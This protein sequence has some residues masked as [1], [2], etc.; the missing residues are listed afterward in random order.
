M[1]NNYTQIIAGE[2]AISHDRVTAAT[3]LLREGATIPFIA[4]YRKET[5]GSMDEVELSAVR[6]R[7]AQLEELDKRRDVI[8]KSLDTRGLLTDELKAKVVGACT[9]TEL[10]D[11]YL[12][13][14]PKRRTR[15]TVAREKGL[16]QLAESIFLQDASLDPMAEAAGYVDAEKGVESAEDALS[17]ARDIIAE[18]VSEDQ[19]A[20]NR[21]RDLFNARSIVRA[22]VVPGEE[23]NGAK[24]RDYFDHE[25]PLNDAPSHRILAMRRGEKLGFLTHRITAPE[26]EAV[27]AL[28]KLFIAADG[29]ASSEHM[30]LALQDG[31]KRLLSPSIETEIRLTAKKRADEEAIRIFAGNLRELLMAPPL[32]QK[33]V[34]AID[35]GFRTGCKLVSLDRQGKLLG[36][37]TIFPHRGKNE[38]EKAAVR[39]LEL[40]GVF[41]IEA[42]AVG[43][44]TAGRETETF[45]KDIGLP[46]HIQVVM[47]D[48]SGASVYSAS[49]TAREEFPEQDVTVRGSIS[50]GRRLM[51]PLAE[52]VKIEPKA[53]GVGQYQHDVDQKELKRS[54]DDI[55]MSSVNR[56]GV[57]VNTASTQLLSY[58]SGLGPALA[59]SIVKFRDDNGPFESRGRLQDVPRLG[60]AAF[61]QSAG[62]LRIRDGANPLDSS[63]VH[64]ESY[65]VVQAMAA[66]L[67]CTV[68]EL[69]SD[70]PLRERIVIESYLSDSVGL[71]TL[72]DILTEL[73]KPGRDPRERFEQLTFA[74]GIE[75]IEDLKTGMTLSG[76]V[77]NITA[78]G[79]FVDIGVHRDGLV[80]VSELADKFVKNPSDIVS[81]RQHVR[82]KVMDIDLDRQRISLS[83]RSGERKEKPEERI[84]DAGFR[85]RKK[86]EDYGGKPRKAGAVQDEK[87]RSSR[88]RPGGYKPGGEKRDERRGTRSSSD[89]GKESSTPTRQTWNPFEEYFKKE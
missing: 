30:L 48:E 86:R 15:A 79:V 54:L 70:T 44:G 55:V 28:S 82:V 52:L 41:K 60:P 6:D 77:T 87:R 5:T 84:E 71:P 21:M 22:K 34:M 26:Y 11:V 8:L 73:A 9:M 78:F 72:E 61:E 75:R 68:T 65:H 14:R 20:R 45:L 19:A 31:L 57:E 25:E 62:F 74:E 83:M 80:H 89:K 36:S 7:L 38:R 43:N 66:D 37:D 59:K 42:I 4:R 63:A 12:P 76:I 2:L 32:G 53:I 23:E 40:C 3:G 10:E 51:D 88:K 29:C 39:I 50:I 58:V 17:G 69:I 47:V 13:F 81:L 64:P 56:V 16:E 49:E 27:A 46:T 1:T 85:D 33:R 24:F 18:R 67:G 35:P